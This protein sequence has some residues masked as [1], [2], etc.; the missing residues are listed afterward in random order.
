MKLDIKKIAD[1]SDMIIN[2]YAFKK[3]GNFIR[4]LNLNSLG[5]ATVLSENGELLETSMDD[6]ENSIVI[7]YYNQN[8][9]YMEV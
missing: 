6:I 5:K 7:D 8:A 9:K 2:G 1:E 3:E 4:V